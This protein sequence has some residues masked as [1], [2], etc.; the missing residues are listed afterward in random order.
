VFPGMFIGAAGAIALSHLPGLPMIAGRRPGDR[1]HDMFHVEPALDG[2]ST[3]DTLPGLRRPGC[4]AHRHRGR[5]G[6]L[7]GPS[8]PS[9]LASSTIGS[10]ICRR[11]ES[12]DS[13]PFGGSG[14]MTVTPMGRCLEGGRSGIIQR[15]MDLVAADDPWCEFRATG[16]DLS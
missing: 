7:R 16:G 8:S 5:R 4:H 2:S 6:H 14:V 9:R 10:R 3:D 11:S 1:R 12:R 13:R 15:C